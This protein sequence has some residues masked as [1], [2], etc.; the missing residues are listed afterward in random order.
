ML[1]F[2]CWRLAR[3]RFWRNVLALLIVAGLLLT[4]VH[5]G[6]DFVF[7]C[8]AILLTWALLFAGAARWAE[9]DAANAGEARAGRDLPPGAVQAGK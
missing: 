4:L 7:Q 8:P 9:L 1:G 3:Q 6:A 2:G 5:S